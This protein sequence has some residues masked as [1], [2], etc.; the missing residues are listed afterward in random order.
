MNNRARKFGEWT[1]EAIAI[2]LGIGLVITLII[3]V[4]LGIRSLVLWVAG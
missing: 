4:A 2:V 1:G 3:L